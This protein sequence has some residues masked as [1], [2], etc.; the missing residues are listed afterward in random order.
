[1]LLIVIVFITMSI[2][3]PQYFNNGFFFFGHAIAFPIGMYAMSRIESNGKKDYIH[4][5]VYIFFCLLFFLSLRRLFE[6][7][8]PFIGDILKIVFAYILGVALGL[9]RQL[10]PNFF[11]FSILRYL[12]KYSL[13]IYILH[14]SFNLMLTSV[15]QVGALWSIAISVVLSVLIA[16]LVSI[17]YK[18][19]IS[20]FMPGTWRNQSIETGLL[21]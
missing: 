19:I 17:F 5:F 18:V 8:S 20:K 16:P 10:K 7:A 2:I 3:D 14:M 15:L 11:G 6:Q 4:F 9:V 21:N 13:E 12:G 1:M